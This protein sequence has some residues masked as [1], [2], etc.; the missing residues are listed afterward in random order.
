MNI[1]EYKTKKGDIYQQYRIGGGYMSPQSKRWGNQPH[2]KGQLKI[3]DM[4]VEIVGWWKT[5]DGSDH[6]YLSLSLN[7]KRKKDEIPAIEF[8][9]IPKEILKEMGWE[10]KK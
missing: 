8:E 7:F 9:A 3:N 10:V 6:K 1:T 2:F 4:P 5:T